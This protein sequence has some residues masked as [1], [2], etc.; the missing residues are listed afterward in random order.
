MVDN[1]NDSSLVN[2]T[3]KFKELRPLKKSFSKDL[4]F[5]ELEQFFLSKL[6]LSHQV[7]KNGVFTLDQRDKS[8]NIRSGTYE[9][10]LNE[11]IDLLFDQ[12]N[13][14]CSSQFSQFIPRNELE[15][16]D[17]NIGDGS[18]GILNKCKYSKSTNSQYAF[19]SFKHEQERSFDSF[20]KE[21]SAYSKLNHSS[22]PKFIGVSFDSEKKFGF[23]MEYINGDD[24]LKCND[25]IDEKDNLEY[26]YQLADVISYLHNNECIHRDLKPNNIIIKS[27]NKL[28]S[29]PRLFLIDYG[30]SKLEDDHKQLLS[31]ST[32]V[33]DNMNVYKF[34][35]GDDL[36]KHKSFDI[37]ALG[38]IIYFL[39]TKKHPC[40]Y[41]SLEL[42]KLVDNGK[43]FFKKDE[44]KD[45][46]IY[47]LIKDC[48]DLDH[49]K[50][51]TAQEIRDKVFIRMHCNTNKGY[52]ILYI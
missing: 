12:Q 36:F 7:K 33:R 5:N 50:R 17:E 47:E 20:S 1:P 26:V 18:F 24:M 51:K 25:L 37:W 28:S 46:F 35:F 22:I 23:L 10:D 11:I 41:D 32:I 30:L 27:L 48:C 15:I 19:K 14:D 43:Y 6:K 31:V 4:K 21:I 2:I 13:N 9:L 8:N 39:Y 16:K 34:L 45:E 49:T 29:K 44:F 38:C 52:S 3:L 40:N 42:K